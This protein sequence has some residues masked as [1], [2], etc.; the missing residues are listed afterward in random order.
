MTTTPQRTSE[1][2]LHAAAANLAGW[3]DCSLRALGL[4]PRFTDQWWTCATP[5]PSIFYTAVSQRRERYPGELHA[6]LLVHLDDPAGAHLAVCDA[7]G[8]LDLHPLGLAPRARLP[9]FARPPGPLPA[10]EPT[11]LDITLVRVAADLAPWE[12]T[13]VRAFA[14]RHPVAPFDIHHPG[15]LEDPA[16]HVLAGR[17]DGE[18]VA[19]AM[20]YVDAGVVGVYGV[21]TL[22]NHRGQGYARA[23]TRA[24]L[25]LGADQAAILQPTPEATSMYHAL[26]FEP[27]GKHTHWA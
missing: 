16:M 11:G 10:D 23:M 18:I 20:A 22:A 8:E 6:E 14:V 2:L 25:A 5:A 21:G 3:H 24:A 4:H 27:V 13:A 9:W 19:V 15:I 26:G 1:D 12:A 7:F 17:A